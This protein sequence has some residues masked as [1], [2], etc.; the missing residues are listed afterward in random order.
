MT[1]FGNGIATVVDDGG[2][3]TKVPVLYYF[4]MNTVDYEFMFFNNGDEGYFCFDDI[5][6][7]LQNDSYG[8][9][10]A[11]EHANCKADLPLL[12]PCGKISE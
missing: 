8:Y 6:D 2:I 12:N 5:E 7:I 10:C 9:N 4:R 1:S 3:T 11:A